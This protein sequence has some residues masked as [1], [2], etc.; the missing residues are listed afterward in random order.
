ME[1][2]R[3]LNVGNIHTLFEL[4]SEE[5]DDINSAYDLYERAVEA[6]KSDDAYISEAYDDYE[7]G[8]NIKNT[9]TPKKSALIPEGPS[10]SKENIPDNIIN[11]LK[12]SKKEIEK[13]RL[14][15]IIR[16]R[17]KKIP[18]SVLELV[19]DRFYYVE[20]WP[21]YAIKIL[22]SEKLDYTRRL[23]LASFFLGNGLNDP[24]IA[25]KIYTAYCTAWS[26]TLTWNIRYTQFKKLFKYLDKPI[27][28]PDRCRIRTNYF[29]YDMERKQTL[30]LN[31]NLRI[32][33]KK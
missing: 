17:N 33:N 7:R 30:F 29:Y 3:K 22:L 31:G 11:N 19:A 5:D 21:A 28:D 10:T 15:A 24:D 13:N 20:E 23:A 27:D 6:V 1:R 26:P 8:L 4:D 18:K 2:K 16:L 14:R 25:W 9:S 32:I 12:N